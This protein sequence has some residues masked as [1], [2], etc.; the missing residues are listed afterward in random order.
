M[1]VT[2]LWMACDGS[3][4]IKHNQFI[5]ICIQQKIIYALLTNL[6]LS[7]FAPP[8]CVYLRTCKEKENADYGH[9]PSMTGP[10][11]PLQPP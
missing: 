9:G 10:I 4:E 2:Y 1:N 11:R 3:G 7:R 6:H 8:L 5:V